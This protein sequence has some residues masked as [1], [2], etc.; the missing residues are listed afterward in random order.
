MNDIAIAGMG[1]Y[2]LVLTREFTAPRARVFAAW[3]D[4]RLAARWWAPQGFTLLSCEMDVRPGGLWHRRLR[5]ADGT[6]IAKRGAYR[7]IA[8]PE[9]LAF[10]YIDEEAD[11][12]TGPETLVT[13]SF[14]DLGGRT[15]LTLR[16]SRFDGEAARL[17][18]DV[19]W[20]GALERFAGF[21]A[22]ADANA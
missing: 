12:S 5:A 21:L 19:G 10:T 13:L 6:V 9:R 18:H 3:T 2:E 4:I 1:A 8:A 7:E 17:S 15:R 14:A 22:A 16:H 11:G 20:R